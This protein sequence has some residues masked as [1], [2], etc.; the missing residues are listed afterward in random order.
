MIDNR[1]AR[2]LALPEMTQNRQENL[3]KSRVLMIGAGGLG[4][5]ALPYL[6]GAGVGH[7]RIADHDAVSRE[8]LHRQ[9][10]YR[11]SDIGQ[12]KA[13][14][15]A[16]YLSDLNPDIEIEARA[17]KIDR[18]IAPG[19]FKNFNLIIDG[20]DNFETKYFLNDISRRTQT[21]LLTASVERFQAMA[22]LFS[23]AAQDPCYACLFPEAPLDAC[24]CN[25]AGI[26]GTSAGLAGLLQAH[27]AL[28]F[29]LGLH[30]IDPGDIVSMDLKTLRLHKARVEKL[31]NCPACAAKDFTMN[32]SDE[33]AILHPDDPVAQSCLIVDVRSHDEIIHTPRPHNI[34]IPLDELAARVEELP[35]DK[36]LAFAC[37]ANI[38][39]MKAAKFLASQGRKD[40]FVLDRTV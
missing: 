14:L 37:L 16:Q 36:P 19:F 40:V 32:A 3:S 17:Q 8:N 11:E 10:I 31:S 7:I 5:A 6:A 35:H 12:S 18:N 28:G 21:P 33:I 23:G 27:I 1:Y 26:L 39:S 38:R 25:E 2:Q 9:T 34:H 22:G 24:N 15:A 13:T 29:L 4:S 20:S 30:F